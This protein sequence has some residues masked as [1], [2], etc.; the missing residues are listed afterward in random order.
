MRCLHAPVPVT[1]GALLH[2]AGV[3]GRKA[4]EWSVGVLVGE[5]W[6]LSA[7]PSFQRY[8]Q[9]DRSAG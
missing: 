1:V 2:P 8:T 7:L 4:G 6:P 9:R 5:S 3:A